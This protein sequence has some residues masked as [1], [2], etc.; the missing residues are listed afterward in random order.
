MRLLRHDLHSL[1]GPYALDA[2]AAEGILFYRRSPTLGRFVCRFD[3]TD[4]EADALVDALR[5]HAP[6]PARAAE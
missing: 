2:L 4:A 3:A 1:A 6:A 5:R